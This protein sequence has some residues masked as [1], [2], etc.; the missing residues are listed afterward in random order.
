[1]KPTP[2]KHCGFVAPRLSDEDCPDNPAR[3]LEGI[4]DRVMKRSIDEMAKRLEERIKIVVKPRPRWMPRFV[5][6]AVIRECVVQQVGAY[7]APKEITINR[8][9]FLKP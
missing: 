7:E 2:C 9:E 3:I 5:Y 4:E 1:M 6:R 8:E